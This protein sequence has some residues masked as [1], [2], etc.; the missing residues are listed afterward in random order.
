MAPFLL[1]EFLGL[2]TL[3]SI[4]SA[5]SWTIL[6]ILVPISLQ[7]SWIF[8]NSPNIYDFDGFEGSYGRKTKKIRHQKYAILSQPWNL[9]FCKDDIFQFFS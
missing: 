6:Q 9:T 1:T 2:P 5:I 8:Q 7:I 4:I 3:N